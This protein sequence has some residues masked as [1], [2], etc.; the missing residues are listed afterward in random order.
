MPKKYFCVCCFEIEL[1]RLQPYR[2]DLYLCKE[3]KRL[4][5]DVFDTFATHFGLVY[6][7]T[8][9]HCWAQ[10]GSSHGQVF[11]TFKRRSL[12]NRPINELKTAGFLVLFV[13]LLK[14]PFLLIAP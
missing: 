2:F 5:R 4:A 14:I 8:D 7:V 6:D 12:A 1:L 13:C 9:T 3:Q 11:E 10:N